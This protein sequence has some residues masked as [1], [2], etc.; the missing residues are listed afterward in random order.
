[1]KCIEYSMF[2]SS[3]FLRVIEHFS[4]LYQTTL[5]VM[6]LGCT[7][8]ICLALLMIQIQLAEVILCS[9][10]IEIISFVWKL[11]FN[12]SILMILTLVYQWDWPC[13]SIRIIILWLLGNSFGIIGLWTKW[14]IHHCTQRNQWRACSAWLVFIAVRSTT[15]AATHHYVL[16]ETVCYQ[17]LWK[18]HLQPWT[19]QKGL[20]KG[21]WIDSIR[22]WKWLKLVFFLLQVTNTAY[23]YFMVLRKFYKWIDAPMWII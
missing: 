15:Y 1:M 14:K 6:F 10:F 8:S 17:I 20:L 4:E 11:I 2:F 5:T 9:K 22:I 13:C 16:S 19:I 18:Y 3:P 23:S 7:A 12:L 21:A